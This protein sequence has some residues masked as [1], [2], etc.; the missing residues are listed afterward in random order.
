MKEKEKK[1]DSEL[2]VALTFLRPKYLK[3]FTDNE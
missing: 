3:Y 1:F 2:C